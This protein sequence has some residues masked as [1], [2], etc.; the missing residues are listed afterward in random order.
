MD[1]NKIK[2]KTFSEIA[3]SLYKD[4]LVEIY[5]GDSFEEISFDQVST[6]KPCVLVGK[7]LKGIGNLLIINVLSN[8]SDSKSKIICLNEF[9]I[10][11]VTEKDDEFLHDYFIQTSN[12]FKVK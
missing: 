2:G 10:S 1:F 8:E 4:K 11:M 12:S 6:K 3:E 7:I 9:N 5:C